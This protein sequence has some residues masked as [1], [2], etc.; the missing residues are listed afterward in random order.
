MD[1]H[2]VQEAVTY[3]E[4]EW[5]DCEMSKD[6]FAEFQ[7]MKAKNTKTLKRKLRKSIPLMKKKKESASA[8]KEKGPKYPKIRIRDADR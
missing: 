7:S 2:I 1:P 5:I 6:D 8:E 4:D 3:E